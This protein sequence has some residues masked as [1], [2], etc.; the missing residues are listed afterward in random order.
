M[1]LSLRSLSPCHQTSD[2]RGRNWAMAQA[3]APT[4]LSQVNILAAA[5]RFSYRRGMSVLSICASL[6]HPSVL[7]EVA[8]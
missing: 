6:H 4:P 5:H 7:A 1:L 3:M 2:L 8:R